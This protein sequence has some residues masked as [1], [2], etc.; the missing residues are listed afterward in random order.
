MRNLALSLAVVLAAVPALAEKSPDFT[1]LPFDPETGVVRYREVVEIPGVPADKIHT[2]VV[3]WIA[4]TYRSVKD[5]VQL[6][7]P[8]KVLVR[9]SVETT[10]T[11]GH[12]LV[13][14]D[15]TV[16]IKDGRARLTID[17]LTVTHTQNSALTDR[18]IEAGPGFGM[19]SWVKTMRE[20][21]NTALL[22]I[23]GSAKAAIRA[24]ATP[25]EE[26]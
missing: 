12:Y 17:S 25:R 19:K 23:L 18:P 20:R 2:A 11:G 14:H 1:P 16:E 26:W 5:V 4:K 13:N 3:E 24:S 15:L 6:D 7:T 9:G 8:Q 21:F 10:Y 22:D